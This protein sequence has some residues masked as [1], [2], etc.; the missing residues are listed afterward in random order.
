MLFEKCGPCSSD[1]WKNEIVLRRSNIFIA[2]VIQIAVSSAGA[3][4]YG[5]TL[6]RFTSISLSFN[7]NWRGLLQAPFGWGT[8]GKTLIDKVIDIDLPRL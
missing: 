7:S 3:A 1:I 5:P 6:P 4:Y 2:I 8:L